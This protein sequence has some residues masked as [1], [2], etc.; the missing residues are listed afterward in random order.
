MSKDCPMHGECWHHGR[1]MAPG[2]STRCARPNGTAGAQSSIA[3]RT[4]PSAR[5]WPQAQDQ[6]ARPWH[7]SHCLLKIRMPYASNGL[8]S[9]P[10][11]ILDL[12][13]A[14]GPAKEGRAGAQATWLPHTNK[15]HTHCAGQKHAV[16]DHSCSFCTSHGVFLMCPDCMGPWVDHNP[17]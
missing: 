13:L 16:C 12:V 2:Q 17:Q 15:T 4:R 14:Y 3:F 11:P 6:I 1:C 8:Q 7:H 9:N 10:I 5:P